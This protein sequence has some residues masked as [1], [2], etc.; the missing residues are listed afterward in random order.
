MIVKKFTKEEIIHGFKSKNSSIINSV[1]QDIYPT[2]ESYISSNNGGAEDASDI[3]QDAM[4]YI[5]EKARINK[6]FIRENV[7]AFI[8]SVCKY[9]WLSKL[10]EKK[11]K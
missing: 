3:F 5:F 9:Q 2:V 4:K 10:N 6:L 7:N 8:I 11:K 1:Y